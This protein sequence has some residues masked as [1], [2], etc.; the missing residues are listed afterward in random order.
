MLTIVFYGRNGVAAKARAAEIRKKGKGKT[1]VYD[2]TAWDGGT[3]G[4][5]A[6][7]ILDCVSYFD[8]QRIEHAFASIEPKEISDDGGAAYQKI[9]AGLTDAIAITRGEEQPVKRRGRKPRAAA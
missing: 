1:V 4:A 9:A 5:D 6:F 8:R 7:E 2:V 3:D